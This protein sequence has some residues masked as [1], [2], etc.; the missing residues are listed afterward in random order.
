[1]TRHHPHR[2]HVAR[3]DAARQSHSHSHSAVMRARQEQA[4]QVELAPDMYSVPAEA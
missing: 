2:P 1:M 4:L 3:V